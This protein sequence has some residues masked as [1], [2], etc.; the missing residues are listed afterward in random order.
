L[1]DLL[2]VYVDESGDAG[3]L[4]RGTRWLVLAGVAETGAPGALRNTLVDIAQRLRQEGPL[5][6]HFSRIRN[7]SVQHAALATLANED[8]TTIVVASDTRR[9]RLG[10]GLAE[11]N[12]QYR[13]ALKLLFERASQL[14]AH[15]GCQL[16]FVVEA[17]GHFD[18]EAFRQYLLRSKGRPSPQDRTIWDVVDISR[19]RT[20][21]KNGEL[22][23]SAADG[24]SYAFL[25]ALEP[26]PGWN[27]A[28]PQLAELFQ[29]HLWTGRLGSR[30]L[31]NGLTFVPTPET[32][33]FLR[34]Y[35]HLRRLLK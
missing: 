11:P 18:V 27:V 13:Y 35:P 26:P 30:V 19:V 23:L 12:V 33:A 31:H 28:T 3:T 5:A 34:E 29:R 24:V 14:A 15:R 7:A 2:T 21:S 16:D 8:F 6:V 17:S 32:P 22:L 1:T 20:I 10:D 9:V 25:R 4:G